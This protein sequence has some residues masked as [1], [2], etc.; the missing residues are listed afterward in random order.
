[1]KADIGE[2]QRSFG[3][4][5]L[6]PESPDDLWHLQHL[7]IP[8]S[9]VFAT[10]LRSVE[11]ATDKIRPEK[12]EKRPVRL[13]IRVEQ[14][15]FHEYAIR[16][17][18]FGVIESGVDEGAHHTL[19]LEPGYEISVIRT[20][21]QADLDRIDQAVKS[22]GADAVYILAI[23]EGE[24]ELY[25]MHSYGPRQIF[26]LTA[27]SGKGMECSTRQDMYDEVSRVLAP[28]TGPLVIAGPGFIK[29]DFTRR[30]RSLQPG[31][32]APVLVTETRRS[33][34]GAV[35]EVIGQGILEKLTGDIQLAREVRYMDELIA[36]IARNEPVAYG[37]K[38]VANAVAC[39]AV[40]TLLV[41]DTGLRTPSVV[42]ILEEAEQMRA[43]V[44]ILSTRFE[45]GARLDKLGGIAALLRYSIS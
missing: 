17:R 34:R 38:D 22:A 43:G 27:G 14:V 44:V 42:I 25:R 20:W 15:E 8:G 29:D 1:M 30:L 4:I 10:T 26:T 39:G 9:L 36:R 18:V 6:F 45:P 37:E 11:G 7:I 12:Q 32:T 16:L 13:G 2:L 21:H 3:E 31:R 41:A 40:E 35:Q 33:G 5:K 23:E 28:V 19:N 24:A